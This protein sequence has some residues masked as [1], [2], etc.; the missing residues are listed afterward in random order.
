M[1]HIYDKFEEVEEEVRKYAPNIVYKYRDWSNT[2]HRDLLIKQELWFSHPFDLNDPYDI[3]TKLRINSDEVKNPL[4]FERLKKFARIRY[5]HLDP[6]GRDFIYI[7]ENQYEII[8]NDPMDYFTKNYKDIRESD[9]YDPVGVLSLTADPIG[10]RI[11]KEYGAKGKGFC[12]GFDTLGLAKSLNVK[13]GKVNYD[14]NPPLYSLLKDLEVYQNDETF[15]KELKWAYEKE[16]R[17][18]TFNVGKESDRT[19]RVSPSIVKEVYFGE[20]MPK[21]KKQEIINCLK[22]VYESSVNLFQV[23]RDETTKLLKSE[24][25]HY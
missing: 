19:A 22:T 10:E 15:T 20:L 8:L 17:F 13:F 14:D 7:C 12:V 11:W 24:Q 25:V 16:F 23:V 9:V 4:F 1:V 6:N 18:L 21:F 3:R 2:F 5:P